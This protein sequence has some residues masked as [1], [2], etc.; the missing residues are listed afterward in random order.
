LF[1]VVAQTDVQTLT[2]EQTPLKHSLVTN[3]GKCLGMRAR[4]SS[5]EAVYFRI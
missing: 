5:Y 3:A 4:F 2:D 1:S